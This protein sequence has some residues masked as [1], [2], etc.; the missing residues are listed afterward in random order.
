METTNIV[1]EFEK[2]SF[3]FEK[4]RYK[5]GSMYFAITKKETKT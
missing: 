1:G 4:K 2:R 3:L 5:T